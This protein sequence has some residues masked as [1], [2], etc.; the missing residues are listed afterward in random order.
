MSAPL[1]DFI[2]EEQR[3]GVKGVEI[4]LRLLL[5]LGESALLR[6]RVFS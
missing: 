1:S 3:K 4:H 5:R 2:K 6:I